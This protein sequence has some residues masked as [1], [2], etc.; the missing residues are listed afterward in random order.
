[1]SAYVAPQVM[2]LYFLIAYH[3][4]V[5]TTSIS[6]N[7]SKIYR[8]ISR[9]SLAL[10]PSKVSTRALVSHNFLYFY[11]AHSGNARRTM[12]SANYCGVCKKRHVT[13]I[14]H[15]VT[16]QSQVPVG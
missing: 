11:S 4:S 3:N 12:T 6:C 14:V 15:D 7:V 9:K 2:K 13:R 1:M 8:D 16:C 5:L 10:R